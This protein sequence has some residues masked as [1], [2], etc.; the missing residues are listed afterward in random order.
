MAPE[1]SL[2]IALRAHMQSEGQQ[3]VRIDESLRFLSESTSVIRQQWPELIQEIKRLAD[4]LDAL[5]RDIA[6]LKPLEQKFLD[7]ELRLRAVESSAL[8]MS[9][10]AAVI[11]AVIG[12]GLPFILKLVGG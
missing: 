5:E 1:S 7:H 11:A 10:Q 6:L 2:E 12:S 3:L 4:K 9:A 8:K